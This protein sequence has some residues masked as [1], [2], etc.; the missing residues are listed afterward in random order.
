[1]FDILDRLA[2][3]AGLSGRTSHD[4]LVDH[5]ETERLGDGG[6][7][8]IGVCSVAGRDADDLRTHGRARYPALSRSVKPFTTW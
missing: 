2:V 4:L 5:P 8:L 1:M 6:C 3:N 7:D